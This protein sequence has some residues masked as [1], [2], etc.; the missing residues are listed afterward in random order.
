MLNG[1]KSRRMG[2][3]GHVVCIGGG[4]NAKRILVGKPKERRPFEEKE[5]MRA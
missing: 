5:F 4:K 3:V 1:D 2:W